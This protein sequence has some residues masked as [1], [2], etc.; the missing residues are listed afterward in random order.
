MWYG[1]PLL[2]FTVLYRMLV[3]FTAWTYADRV[4]VRHQAVGPAR[5]RVKNVSIIF[6]LKKFFFS[7]N[8]CNHGIFSSDIMW[9]R[10]QARTQQKFCWC[11]RAKGAQRLLRPASK[12]N[13]WW[14]RR[15]HLVR[16]IGRKYTIHML[17][18]LLQIQYRPF[19]TV[20]RE[21]VRYIGIYYCCYKYSIEP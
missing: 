7:F 13:C 2:T 5:W 16:Y 15:D 1:T 14:A 4:V 3:V 20:D 8:V 6:C 9:L 17:L 12:C 19:G 21:K 10:Y 18:L 11:V